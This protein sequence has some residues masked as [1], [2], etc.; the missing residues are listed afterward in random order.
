VSDGQPGI[1]GGR[2]E[3]YLLLIKRALVSVFSSICVVIRTLLF[4][5]NMIGG[6]SGYKILSV[7]AKGCGLLVAVKGD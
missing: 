4:A 7:Q 2:Y 3:H 6:F 1:R 5:S